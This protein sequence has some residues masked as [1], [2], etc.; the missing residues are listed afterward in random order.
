[1][2]KIGLNLYINTDPYPT[3]LM[4]DL[5]LYGTVNP[6]PESDSHDGVYLRRDDMREIYEQGSL[7]NKPVLIEHTGDAIG[8]VVAAWIYKDRL[9]CVLKVK[10]DSIEGVVAQRY[11]QTSPAELSLSYNVLMRHSADGKIA[12][13]KKE[14]LEVSIVRK[15]ARPNCHV[16]AVGK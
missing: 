8:S 13:G 16:H 9:D 4:P 2:A 3:I 7:L 11:L 12:P 10:D 14:M 15:G 1:V 6:Q 5:L